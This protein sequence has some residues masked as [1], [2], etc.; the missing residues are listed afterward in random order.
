M[1]HADD[2]GL[3]TVGFTKREALFDFVDVGA[4]K[5]RADNE[6]RGIHIHMLP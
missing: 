6:I 5:E 3:F 4:G 2:L 1:R